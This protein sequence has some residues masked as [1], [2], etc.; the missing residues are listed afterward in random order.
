MLLPVLA[1]ALLGLTI[2]LALPDRFWNRIEPSASAAAA[3][4]TPRA[5]GRILFSSE[6]TGGDSELYMMNADG[7]Q[8]TNLTNAPGNDWAPAWSPDGTKIAF[9]SLRN[10]SGQ[11]IYVMGADGSAPPTK[12]TSGQGSDVAPDWSPD[13]KKIVFR[14]NIYGTG[15]SGLYVV[16]ANG[17]GL[18]NLTDNP[19]DGS[20]V[21][22]PDGTRIA[23]TSDLCCDNSEIYVMNADGSQRT[24]LTD[25]PGMDK[26]P[27]W[28]PDGTKIVFSSNRD[29]EHNY[30]IYI[31]DADG[32]S[33]T[34][35]T[36]NPGGDSSPT[37]SPDGTQIAFTSYNTSGSNN[38]VY[39]INADGSEQKNLTNSP[40]ND[41][42][43]DWQALPVNP[44]GYAQFKTARYNVIEN[45]GTATMTVTRS[46]GSTGAITVNYAATNGT[47]TKGA[48]YT[49]TQGKLT[50]AD[51]ETIKTISVPVLDD[52]IVEPDE[53]VNVTLSNPTGGGALAQPVRSVLNLIDSSRQPILSVMSANVPEDNQAGTISDNVVK[54]SLSAA[55]GRVV[56]V[57]YSTVAMTAASGRDFQATSGT[58]IFNPGETEQNVNVSILGD[59]LNEAD[60]MFRLALASPANAGLS[61]SSNPPAVTIIDNDP[62]PS[63]SVNDATVTEGNTGTI[64][65]VFTV[66]LSA[67]SGQTVYVPY[68]AVP[69]TA[70]SP[71][72]FRETSGTLIFN[73]GQ[74][75]KTVSVPVVGD[76]TFEGQE[77]FV[78]MAYDAA[79]ATIA[80]GEGAGTILDNESAPTISIGDASVTEGNTGAPVMR[81]VVKLSTASSD[82]VHFKYETVNGTAREYYDYSGG[83][84]LFA[85][86]PGTTRH[87]I[88]IP[89]EGDR[90]DEED[91]TFFIK[92]SEV[93]NATIADGRAVFTIVDNDPPP[94]LSITNVST[95]ETNDGAVN[96][97]FTVKLSTISG[98]T[99]QVDYTTADGT[100]TAGSD[101]TAKS[102]T[103]LI[104]AGRATA[105]ITIPI[106]GDTGVEANETFFVNLAAPVNASITD[107]QGVG[108]IVNND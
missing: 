89:I 106:K 13:G 87:F 79:G 12:I 81:V 39:V 32:G 102:G 18:R 88:D 44:A 17:T 31:M 92:L 48:D 64:R 91:E 7:S 42:D 66:K 94:A 73:P 41:S 71:E 8:Q 40:S 4:L 90:L 69:E 51:G 86:D 50:F 35:L 25:A 53:T 99:A 21:W 101:Y 1:L 60:E 70:S 100:A 93:V 85:F 5:N 54:V 34:R 49:A 105:I 29:N 63:L 46:G 75:T 62:M 98:K 56:T 59:T 104:P 23:F 19:N 95:Q 30:E 107:A 61:V 38:E 96:A 83:S 11:K 76:L 24:K 72:D 58:L 2:R 108:T 9:L 82:Y 52:G 45:I 97:V 103:L 28:S 15:V 27:A 26:S 6:R 65:A 55:T 3:V 37:W 57:D 47:A 20:P 22:S 84:G 78:F 68:L 14:R 33:P 16:Y 43:P 36:Y 80:D 74:T 77:T 67:V 10:N